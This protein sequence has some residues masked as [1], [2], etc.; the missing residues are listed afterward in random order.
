LGGIFF[1]GFFGKFSG[2]T[3]FWKFSGKT[4]F[5]EVLGENFFWEVLGETSVVL[6]SA[7]PLPSVAPPFLAVRYEKSFPEPLSKTFIGNRF[8]IPLLKKNF[9]KIFFVK[10]F[11]PLFSKSG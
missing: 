3:F 9:E 6:P 8:A 11:A 10:V 1:F 4:F 5:F 7:K 2:K